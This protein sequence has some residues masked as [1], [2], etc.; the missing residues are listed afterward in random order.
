LNK[1]KLNLLKLYTLADT[2]Y[3]KSQDF[4]RKKRALPSF[5]A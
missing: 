1:V 4:A 3:L 2:I 5:L